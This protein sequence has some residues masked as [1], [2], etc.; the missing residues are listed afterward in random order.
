[1]ATAA[2][3]GGGIKAAG[4]FASDTKEVSKGIF[5]L[6]QSKL[7]SKYAI[8]KIKTQFDQQLQFQH[9]SMRSTEAFFS[10]HNIPAAYAAGVKPMFKVTHGAVLPH[11]A[12]YDPNKSLVQDRLGIY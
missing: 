2:M 3:I 7:D 5:G 11:Y 6:V 1:M 8:K 12:G 4:K 9:D 10:K